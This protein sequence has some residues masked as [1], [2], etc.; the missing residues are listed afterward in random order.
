MV[1]V[2]VLGAYVGGK[3]PGSII[4]VTAA[5]AAHLISIGYAKPAEISAAADEQPNEI[6]APEEEEAKAEAPKPAPA[7]RGK[8]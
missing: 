8:K 7:K 3:G 6:V 5:Q 4:E 2:E 1:S